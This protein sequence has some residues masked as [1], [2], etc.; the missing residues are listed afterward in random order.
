M[1]VLDQVSAILKQ[2]GGQVWTVSATATVY[3]ALGVMANREIGALLVV[4]GEK[5]LGVLSERDYAR[6]IILQGRSSKET[7][8]SEVMAS[9]PITIESKC[10]VDD[11]MRIMT[12]NRIR[13][14]PVV[15]EGG[16][17]AGLIS[18]GDLIKWIITSQGQTIEQLESYIAGG[19]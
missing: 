10:S 16:A 6:K 11:A 18:I 7:K 5:L 9:P 1:K 8:V 17:L 19:G 3:E 2:K 12:E 15:D 4:D 14:L 13:H